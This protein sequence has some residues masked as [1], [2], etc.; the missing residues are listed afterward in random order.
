MYLLSMMT[1]QMTDSPHEA[2][3][4]IKMKS[5]FEIE[6]LIDDFNDMSM[7]LNESKN[8]LAHSY[9]IIEEQKNFYDTI[10]SNTMDSIFV[11][12][13]ENIIEYMNHEASRIHG[14]AIGKYCCKGNMQP[15]N[16]MSA[17][18]NK[19]GFKWTNI[20]DRKNH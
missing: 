20:K 14:H 10:L 5:P 12:N 9:K 17:M 18:W 2:K 8:K 7:K 4:D 19:R 11:M 3:L 16:C 15:G 6:R 13:K 1:K